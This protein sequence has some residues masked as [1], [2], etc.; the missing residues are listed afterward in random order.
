MGQDLRFPFPVKQ[1]VF[2][3]AALI[4]INKNCFVLEIEFQGAKIKFFLWVQTY[5]MSPTTTWHMAE[6]KKNS[7][8]TKGIFCLDVKAE[9]LKSFS[10]SEQLAHILAVWEGH[11]LQCNSLEMMLSLAHN[12]IKG[13]HG[14]SLLALE[15]GS[16]FAQTALTDIPIILRCPLDYGTRNGTM[17][18]L[19]RFVCCFLKGRKC[20]VIHFPL[21]TH[22]PS[23]A[24]KGK[25]TSFSYFGRGRREC[26]GFTELK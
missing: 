1:S 2:Q 26:Q 17:L 13:W 12:P 15:I 23:Q 24:W 25:D 6:R 22:V 11:V 16:M 4:F 20:R 19:A 14:I 21:V 10:F 7:N 3:E 9:T 8:V 5:H 18:Y